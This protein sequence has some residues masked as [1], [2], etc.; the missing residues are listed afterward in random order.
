[1]DTFCTGA[2]RAKGPADT[3][4]A[5]LLQNATAEACQ[6]THTQA[7]TLVGATACLYSYWLYVSSISSLVSPVSLVTAAFSLVSPVSLVTAAFYLVSLVSPAFY[8]SL[9]PRCSRS[10]AAR[11]A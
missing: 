9:Q 6:G 4:H 5:Q 8:V 2:K 11:P 1:M 10:G 7:S 3:P